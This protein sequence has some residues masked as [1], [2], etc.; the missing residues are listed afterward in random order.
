MDTIATRIKKL[1]E[2]RNLTQKQVADAVK[3]SR[4]AVTKWEN[5]ETENLKLDNLLNICKLFDIGVEGLIS[6]KDEITQKNTQSE[7]LSEH[8]R[9]LVIKYATADE[10]TKALVDIALKIENSKLNC[11]NKAV[12]R[13]LDALLLDI[14]DSLP[15]EKSPRGKS[16]PK[17]A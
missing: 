5:G 1:R 16:K 8:D 14:K 11:V 15:T 13:H 12:Y 3:V 17:A 6:G 7:H 9:D 10:Q 4:V 2:A